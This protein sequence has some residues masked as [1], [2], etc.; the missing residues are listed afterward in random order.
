MA[1]TTFPAYAQFL[2]DGY[3]VE[4]FD[5]IERSEM[6]DGYVQQGPANSRTRYEAEVAYR[7]HSTAERDSFEAWRVANGRGS[8]HFAWPDPAD[9]VTKRAR[10]LGGKVRYQ[11]L[12]KTRVDEWTV[13]FTVE[14]FA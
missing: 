9:G 11:P 3:G 13:S 14:Y 7:L 4:P 6:E 2:M 10:I 1:Y 5:G 8:L 12:T